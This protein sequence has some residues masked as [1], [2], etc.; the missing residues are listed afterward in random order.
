MVEDE[1]VT[2]VEPRPAIGNVELNECKEWKNEPN[3]V[4]SM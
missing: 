3:L 4:F 1:F 2:E